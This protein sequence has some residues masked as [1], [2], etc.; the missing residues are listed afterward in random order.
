M[1]HRRQFARVVSCNTTA[2]SRIA[3]ALQARGWVKR[4]RAV[5]MRRGTDPWESHA[6]GMINTVVPETVVPSH[7]GP[8]A[9]TVLSLG[10][11]PAVA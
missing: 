11:A 4:V 7:Q 10:P 2:L 1:R 9:Q 6:S 3:H 5:L 8:D